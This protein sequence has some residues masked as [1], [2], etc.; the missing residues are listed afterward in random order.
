MHPLPWFQT[1]RL[2][3][4][5]VLLGGHCAVGQTES[6]ANDADIRQIRETFGVPDD[7]FG[8]LKITKKLYGSEIV[9]IYARAPYLYADTLCVFE[10]HTKL[11]KKVDDVIQWRADSESVG[12]KYWFATPPGHCEAVYG[13]DVPNAVHVND[14]IDIDSVLAIMKY[15][16]GLIQ[17]AIARPDGA[18]FGE[19]MDSRLVDISLVDRLQD[20]PV[21]GPFFAAMYSLPSRW[22]GPV[23]Y[24]RVVD[25]RFQIEKVSSWTV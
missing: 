12:I 20:L 13:E 9:G 11:G 21:D 3:V 2:A 5:A 25:G 10:T 7:D 23:V 8:V 19:W 16:R 24:F 22:H 4:L 15:E 18:Q 17:Q 14:P 1:T 6:D